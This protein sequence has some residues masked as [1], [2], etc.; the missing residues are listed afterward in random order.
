MRRA[1]SLVMAGTLLESVVLQIGEAAM[2]LEPVRPGH[3]DGNDEVAAMRAVE[4]QG[5][6][7]LLEHDVDPS[8]AH[9][10]GQPRLLFLVAGP[11]GDVPLGG[12]SNL[13]KPL[14]R[15]DA[16]WARRDLAAKNGVVIDR[17]LR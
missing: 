12:E 13:S 5:Q 7:H 2:G 4:A 15:V 1:S 3:A 11:G 16:L 17:Q 14:E 10:P 8:R 9:A 6:G